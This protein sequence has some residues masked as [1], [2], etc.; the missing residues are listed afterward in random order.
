MCLLNYTCT[1]LSDVLIENTW[2]QYDFIPKTCDFKLLLINVSLCLRYRM[3][4]IKV[5]T[6]IKCIRYTWIVIYRHCIN[7]IKHIMMDFIV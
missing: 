1:G 6:L 2:D 7:N 3:C 4:E 5:N